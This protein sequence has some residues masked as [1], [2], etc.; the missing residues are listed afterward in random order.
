[1]MSA[2]G[3]Q[4]SEDGYTRRHVLARAAVGGGAILGGSAFL[5]ACGGASTP[6]S[7]ASGGTPKQGGNLR[8]AMTGGASSGTIDAHKALLYPDIIRVMA[9]YNGL[10]RLSP[11]AREVVMDL[12]EEITPSK[13]ARKWTIRLKK[14]VT[15]HDGKPLTAAD[16]IYT[17]RRI[18]DPKSPLVGASSLGPVDR[19]AMRARDSLTVEIPM[20]TPYATFLEQISAYYNL[21]IVP[22]GYDP[23]A[24][25]G[26]GPFKYQSYTPGQQSV[27]ARNEHYFVPGRPYLDKLTIIDSFAS[28]TAAFNAI[29]GGQVD[30][31]GTATV[32][33]SSQATGAGLRVLTSL[34]GQWTPFT[35]RLDR[36]PFDD[37]RVRQAFRL[38][39]NRPQLIENSLSGFGSVGN[40]IF[41]QWDPFYRADLKRSQDL[42]QAKS[43]LKQAGQANL[44]VELVTADIAAGVVAAAQIFAQQAKSAGVTVKINRVPVNTF[45]GPQYKQWTFSQDFWGYSPYF[46]QIS[47]GMLSGSPYNETHWSDPKYIKLFNQANATTNTAMQKQIAAE[48]QDIDFNTGGYIIGSY[49]KQIDIMTSKVKGFE[50]LGAGQDL[51]YNWTDAALAT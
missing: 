49:N 41:G 32:S 24:P 13:D 18:T 29:Q 19:N 22:E 48:M 11:N 36:K 27:F 7:S 45:F 33:L 5:A 17:Y 34:P 26:T 38:M 2:S 37:V 21:G 20:M 4:A 15:F 46:N 43:L 28:D 9:L 50:P 40:D 31:Y 51:A 44:T 39:V 10:V 8:V 14:G 30:V 12:A 3:N 16:V 47:L 25:I 1:M 35:M 23:K 6:A 42:E